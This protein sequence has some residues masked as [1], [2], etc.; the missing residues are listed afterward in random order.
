MDIN[1][2]QSL[3][4]SKVSSLHSKFINLVHHEIYVFTYAI[5]KQLHCE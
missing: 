5:K 3:E 4:S 1:T 2:K